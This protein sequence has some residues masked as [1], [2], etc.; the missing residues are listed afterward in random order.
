M[1]RAPS[2]DAASTSSRGMSCSAA[3]KMITQK[4][5]PLQSPIATSTHSACP[6]SARKPWGAIPTL[7]STAFAT[8]N[9]ASNT[10]ENSTPCAVADM[11][12]GT[13]TNVR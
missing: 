10:N 11:M 13:N 2:I 7:S 4:P 5:R 1:R 6:G 8:P 9:C 12:Y 3:R